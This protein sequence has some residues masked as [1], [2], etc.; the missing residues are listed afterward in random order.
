MPQRKVKE[1][2]EWRYKWI[3]ASVGIL[4][5]LFAFVISVQQL[6]L[7]R[8]VAEEQIRQNQLSVKPLLSFYREM[9]SYEPLVGIRLKNDGLG[10]AHL[11]SIQLF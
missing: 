5:A 10:A 7:S 9:G 4:I 3:T 2:L 1:K 8:Q 11:D 6:K